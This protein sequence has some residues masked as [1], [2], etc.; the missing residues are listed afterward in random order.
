MSATFEPLPTTRSTRWPCSSPISSASD[1]HASKILNQRSPSIATAPKPSAS[2]LPPPHLH[3][4]DET[5]LTLGLPKI[6]R[7]APTRS[8]LLRDEAAKPMSR[9]LKSATSVR[10]RG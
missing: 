5:A 9:T 3:P 6:T 4:S 8:G 10:A 2:A 7:P 1:L